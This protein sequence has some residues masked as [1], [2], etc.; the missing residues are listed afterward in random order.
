M[1][2]TVLRR[3]ALVCSIVVPTVGHT[4]TLDDY[5]I[6]VLG[7]NSTDEDLSVQ[8]SDLGANDNGTIIEGDAA[9]FSGAS[10][11]ASSNT[12]VFST[13]RRNNPNVGARGIDC[14]DRYSRC[15]NDISSSRSIDNTGSNG[16][17]R[18]RNLG[19][20]SGVYGNAPIGDLK[21][22]LGG[23]FS[24]LSGQGIL[25]LGGVSHRTGRGSNFSR[26]DTDFTDSSFDDF[27]VVDWDVRGNNFDDGSTLDFVLRQNQFVVFRF[28]DVD[29]EVSFTGSVSVE[30]QFG[31][32]LNNNLMFLHAEN[33]SD[34]MLF[35]YDSNAEFQGLSTWN[36]GGNTDNEIDISSTRYCGQLVSHIVKI[37]SSDVSECAFD[38][39][40]LEELQMAL[41]PVPMP[42]VMLGS[43]I[44][45]L[46]ALRRSRRA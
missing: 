3:A 25:T 6:V 37:Q 15:N 44:V 1:A 41:I 30:D 12:R 21:D 45:G 28:A 42:V 33:T 13:D 2:Y 46:G 38:I 7:S 17:N 19:N 24:L 27:V 14:E 40:S 34:S 20:N 22:D 8:S 26:L 4:L 36:L 29:S 23:Y 10:V 32:E 35:N 31:N 16:G 9:V 43:A 5:A 11:K 39:S 18:G